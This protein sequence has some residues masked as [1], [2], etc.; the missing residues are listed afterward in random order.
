MPAPSTIPT[1]SLQKEHYIRTYAMDLAR[2][3]PQAQAGDSGKAEQAPGIVPLHKPLPKVPVK[4][5]KDFFE[6]LRDSMLPH[7][8]TRITARSEAVVH[9]DAYSESDDS[10]ITHSQPPQ[11]PELSVLEREAEMR[12]QR[13]A[14]AER[15]I[16]AELSSIQPPK[17]EPIN[18]AP[19]LPVNEQ[20]KNTEGE[21]EAIL[22][23]L[24][25]RSQSVQQTQSKLLDLPAP[26]QP[27]I[28]PGTNVPVPNQETS[29]GALQQSTSQATFGGDEHGAMLTRLRARMGEGTPG[30]TEVDA[31][32]PPLS[33]RSAL[34][35]Q[36]PQAAPVSSGPYVVPVLPE[37]VPTNTTSNQPQISQPF[38]TPNVAPTTPTPFH[39]YSSDFASRV[40]TEG[41]S[42]FSVLA[43]QKD[44]APQPEAAPQPKKT[45][46]LPIA[47]GVVL[48][49][50]G[51]VGVLAA[52]HFMQSKAPVAI[53]PTVPS[54]IK[55]D[56][57]ALLTGSYLAGALMQVA[58]QPLTQGEVVVTYVNLST[59]TQQGLVQIPQPGGILIADLKLPAP[60][61][62]LRNV[63]RSSTVGV[64]NDGT[65]TKPFF[66]L[67]VIS[68]DRTFIGM[69][70]WES[71]MANDLSQYYPAYPV[72]QV[73]GTSTATT[74]QNIVAQPAPASLQFAD[75]IV[76]SHSVRVLRDT[77]G[78]SLMLYGYTAD[79]Q[80]LIIARD[81]QAFTLLLSR[82]SASG[83]GN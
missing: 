8:H 1:T 28:L 15:E 62:L 38:Q 44:A 81:E 55:A 53:S 2:M 19:V 30:A 40:D 60:D 49:V 35:E 5:R 36:L 51:A 82:L 23:R 34:P 25:E 37:E 22:A 45:Y 73:T 46:W 31:S 48:I 75:E 14:D 41:A 72:A 71:T 69:L 42:T 17:P 66:L 83:S 24:R 33:V 13:A 18:L 20:S 16:T 12:D 79:K 10:L 7:P 58:N 56:S 70:D 63:D 3:S 80:T 76:N 6:V 4:H 52:Y 54:L 67:H 64:V 50:G 9:E 26:T 74:T 57:Y 39:S 21:R 59:T 77:T 61:I 43:A 11:A 65:D 68:Y 29:V 27:L 32:R 47:A 78:R